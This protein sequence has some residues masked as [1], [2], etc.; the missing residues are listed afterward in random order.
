M[1]FF[2][3]FTFV[4]SSFRMPPYKILNDHERVLVE[5]IVNYDVIVE[6][7]AAKLRQYDRNLVP[8]GPAMGGKSGYL[9]GQPRQVP[10]HYGVAAPHS[11]EV[12]RVVLSTGVEC[13]PSPTR[14]YRDV[15]WCCSWY[16]SCLPGCDRVSSPAGPLSHRKGS[17]LSCIVLSST[18]IVKTNLTITGMKTLVSSLIRESVA[19]TKAWLAVVTCARG[20]TMQEEEYY[21]GGIERN[22]P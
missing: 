4:K 18:Q 1:S 19:A 3:S 20:W 21:T 8:S 5:T 16:P 12:S 13:A 14:V 22:P 10:C 6:R 11:D 9:H 15:F 7:C 2:D 17:I